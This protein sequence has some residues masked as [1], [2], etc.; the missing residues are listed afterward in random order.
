MKTRNGLIILAVVTVALAVGFFLVSDIVFDLDFGLIRDK[1]VSA[2]VATLTLARDVLSLH[3]V[4]VVY[5]VVFPHDFVPADMDWKLF[6]EQVEAGR[7][8]SL[9]EERYLA[10]YELCKDL[11]IKLERKRHEFVVVTAIIKAGFDL[12]GPVYAAPETAGTLADGYVSFDEAGGISIAIPDAVI[13]DTIIEDADTESYAYPDIRI[14]PEDW[15]K[16]TSFVQTELISEAVAEGILDLARENGR[17]FI[18]RLFL[19]SG[20]SAVY[21]RQ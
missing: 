13:T 8:L 5:K 15:R 1:T 6:L 9:L 12:S 20:Y 2:S 18:E 10:A 16:L 17:N 7:G 14:G 21:F 19:D 11:G 4:E 3:T